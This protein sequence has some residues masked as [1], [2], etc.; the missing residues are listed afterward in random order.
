MDVVRFAKIAIYNGSFGTRELAPALLSAIRSVHSKPWSISIVN[1]LESNR[2]DILY[3]IICPAGLKKDVILPKK[4]ITWQL[5]YMNGVYNNSNYIN[6]L[7]GAITNWDYSIIN[8]NILKDRDNISSVHVPPGFDSIISMNDIIDGSYIYSDEGKD[9]DILFL[10]YCDAYPRR[11]LFR[12]NCNRTGLKTHF[13]SDLDLE[14]MKNVIRRSKVCINMAA[15][16][17][18]ILATVRLNILLSNQACIVSEFSIDTEMDNLYSKQGICFTPYNDLI[19]KAYD[20]VHNYEIR[21]NMAIKSYQWYR[22]YRKWNDI[23]NFNLL[24]PGL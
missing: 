11:R 9:I 6:I 3:I 8:I 1:L 10:G 15:H 2:D 21:K 17:P 23:V 20:L 16:D 5:E 14:G 13:V 22:N 12:D 18:F 19:E 7:R 4:Y 24:L